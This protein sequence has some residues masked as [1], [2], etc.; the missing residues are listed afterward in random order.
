MTLIAEVATL[1]VA[2]II[3]FVLWRMLENATQLAVNSI[4]GI[5]AFWLLNQFF[6]LGIPI[7]WLSILVV[8]LA[9]IPGVILVVLIHFL[10]LGF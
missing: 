7:N 3:I 5:I 9:G 8:A 4:I 1:I 6:G 2:V 10:G